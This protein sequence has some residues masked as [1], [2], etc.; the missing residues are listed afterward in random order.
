MESSL[1]IFV[2]VGTIG[3]TAFFVWLITM[4]WYSKRLTNEKQHVI[5]LDAQLQALQQIRQQEQQNEERLKNIIENISVRAM[6]NNS[7]MYL[8]QTKE[9]LSGIVSPLLK[10]MQRL[11]A[12]IASIEKQREGAFKSLDVVIQNL[13][14]DIVH[15]QDTNKFLSNSTLALNQALR[16]D[17]KTRGSW[18]ELQLRRIAEISGMVEYIDFAEQ[19][20]TSDGVRPDMIIK[21]PK[22]GIIPVDAKTPMSA[23]LDACQ[24]KTEEEKKLALDKHKKSLQKHIIDL[25][26]KEYWGQFPH[27]P[28][29]V[30]MFVPYESG[31][32]ASF[33]LYPDLLDKALQH[34]VIVVGPSSLYALLKVISYGWMQIEL[35]KNAQEIS[36]ASQELFQR[37][38]VFFDHYTKIGNQLK[39][40]VASYNNATSSFQRRVLPQL[41]RIQDM[42]VSQNTLPED[43]DIQGMDINN[44]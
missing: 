3:I 32:E 7:Q 40:T 36:Q 12:S 14:K 44:I 25:S 2:I 19:A 15:L 9:Q 6:Q 23:Y 5:N 22:E 28:Q 20:H 8:S 33:S 1:F 27:T 13:S 29:L 35:T 18:G 21:L 4:T 11:D 10:D 17:I 38:S 42:G 41:R 24:A 16:S 31:L 43:S 39:N 30:I 37:F 26:K 34:K